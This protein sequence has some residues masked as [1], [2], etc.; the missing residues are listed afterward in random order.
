MA[1]RFKLR[2]TGP[3]TLTLAHVLGISHRSTPQMGAYRI[4]TPMWLQCDSFFF[5]SA[6]FFYHHTPRPGR[7]TLST[8]L[9]PTS[10]L[11]ILVLCKVH[12]ACFLNRKSGLTCRRMVMACRQFFTSALEQL[13]TAIVGPG[14]FFKAHV[15][16]PPRMKGRTFWSMDF[17]PGRHVFSSR[18]DSDSQTRNSVCLMN[19]LNW[20]QSYRSI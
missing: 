14:S 13:L 11:T 7:W 4:C 17:Q 9:L 15:F 5:V 18:I 3:Y 20:C 10:I 16:Y 19:H 8:F 2:Y 6:L 1:R 12:M